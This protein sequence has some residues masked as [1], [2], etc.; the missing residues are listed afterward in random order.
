VAGATLSSRTADSMPSFL[1]SHFS[2]DRRERPCIGTTSAFSAA[3]SARA[4][5]GTRGWFERVCIASSPRVSP[6][7]NRRAQAVSAPLIAVASSRTTGH[8]CGNALPPKDKELARPRPLLRRRRRDL[9]FD[10]GDRAVYYDVAR[11][12]AAWPL[13]HSHEM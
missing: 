4:P 11:M 6:Q 1:Q 9:A 13:S 12:R 5:A 10:E 7:L 3:S 8:W 2:H